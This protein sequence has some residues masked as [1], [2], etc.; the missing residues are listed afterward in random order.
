MDLTFRSGLE[1]E[2]SDSNT[3]I[4]GF[5]F[6][7]LTLTCP[8]YLLPMR[9]LS[10]ILLTLAISIV[11]VQ[12]W[13]LQNIKI[14]DKFRK[15]DVASPIATAMIFLASV[16]NANAIEQQYKLPPIDYKDPNRCILTSSSIG[17]A[18]AARDKLYD[19]R[20]CDLR[21]QSGAGK[22][23]SGMIASDADFTGVNLKEALISK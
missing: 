10:A 9:V 7:I 5:I 16:T 17:Q 23:L 12:A 8:Q 14:F 3:Q 19:L 15:L 18:N 22:D 20:Q 11:A 1:S 4:N 13:K 2:V 6:P 21:K